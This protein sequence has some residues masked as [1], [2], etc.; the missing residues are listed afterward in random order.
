VAVA[1][2]CYAGGI[3][4]Y[5]VRPMFGLG[6]RGCASPRICFGSIAWYSSCLGFCLKGSFGALNVLCIVLWY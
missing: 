1:L 2:L 4:R 6:I 3:A 5:L